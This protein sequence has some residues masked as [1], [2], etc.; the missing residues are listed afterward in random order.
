MSL[1]SIP[2][3]LALRISRTAELF[4]RGSR[5]KGSTGLALLFLCVGSVVSPSRCSYCNSVGSSST[6]T[7]SFSLFLPLFL[8]PFVIPVSVMGDLLGQFSSSSQSP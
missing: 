2:F 8:G 1:S 5:E 4:L 6:Q 3:F 7:A